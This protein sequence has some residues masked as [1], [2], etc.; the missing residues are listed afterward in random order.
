MA[1]I[2]DP[3]QRDDE[4]D[5]SELLGTLSDHK[6]LI[7]I[8]TGV[9][10]LLSIAYAMLTTPIYQATSVV[11]VEQ[12]VPSLPGL[13]ALTQTLGASSPEA[14]TETAL[15]TSRMV[16]GAAVD[17]LKL[18]IETHPRRMPV[19]GKYF[20]RKYAASNPGLVSPP[21]F[22]KVEY[23]WGGSK[24]EIFQLDVP[25]SLLDQPLTLIASRKGG[26]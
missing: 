2:Q 12:K 1:A 25:D 19:I 3:V 9:F 7:G 20:A 5:L 4:I 17:E 6:W 11:Q 23:D 10:V 14:T 15:I 24:L 18:A 26:Y 8:I 22:N 21:L 16:L 13:S